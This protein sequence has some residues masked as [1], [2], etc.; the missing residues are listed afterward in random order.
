M[1]IDVRFDGEVGSG[2]GPTHEFCGLLAK[3]LCQKS[4]NLW[5]NTDTDPA[6]PYAF[7]PIGL[8]PRPDADVELFYVLGLLCGKVLSMN[9]TLSIPLSEE[10]IRFCGG[11]NLALSDVD[12]ELAASLL[13]LGDLI[14]AE[15]PFTYP[16]IESL[17]LMPRGKMILVTRTNVKRYVDAV[18]D[19][20]SGEKLAG[21]RERFNAGLFAVLEGGIWD[22]LPAR[23]RLLLITGE[24]AELTLAGLQEHVVFS[25]GYDQ[26]SPQARMLLEVVAE[27]NGAMQRNWLLFVTGCER[28][29]IGGLGSLAPKITVAQRLPDDPGQ[30]PD[31]TF[32]TAS[33]CFHYFKLPAYSSKGT[34]RK[35]MIEAFKEGAGFHMS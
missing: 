16:G 25:H 26:R 15:I 23:D 21:V 29:P 7:T 34:M 1:A 28:L 6:N 18:T 17:E 12:S 3:Q 20:T 13:H 32:P 22:G 5:R 33:V 8:F 10:F 30:D 11:E 9:M 35:K 2:I 24:E 19:F 27:F 31:D 14:E 4:L